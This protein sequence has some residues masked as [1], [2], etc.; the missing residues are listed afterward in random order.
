M[1]TRKKSES[2]AYMSQYDTEV[3]TRLD[4]LEAAVAQLQSHSH[5]SG[6]GGGDVASQLKYVVDELETRF[7]SPRRSFR[8]P[9]E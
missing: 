8:P 4:A 7:P 2:G 3:E 9:T 5:D 6:S 1:A